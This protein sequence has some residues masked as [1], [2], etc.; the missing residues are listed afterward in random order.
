MSVGA[1][2]CV[3]LG[4]QRRDLGL[5]AR[6]DPDGVVADAQ[7]DLLEPRRDAVDG[8]AGGDGVLAA[9]AAQ[10]VQRPARV[11]GQVAQVAFDACALVGDAVQPALAGPRLDQGEAGLLAAG[12]VQLVEVAFQPHHQLGL[13]DHAIAEVALHQRGVDAQIERR[14][15]PDRR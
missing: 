1:V 9:H 10:E 8:A 4:V 7:G 11:L 2:E 12:T 13:A 14:Q 6:A 5:D 15:Q 3:E